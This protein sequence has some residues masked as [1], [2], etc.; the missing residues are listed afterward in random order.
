MTVLNQKVWHVYLNTPDPADYLNYD[1]GDA[2]FDITGLQYWQKLNTLQTIDTVTTDTVSAWDDKSSNGRDIENGTKATQPD[3]TTTGPTFDNTDFLSGT[4]TGLL[5][6]V[7][8]FF[9]AA[10]IK[11]PSLTPESYLFRL[12]TSSSATNNRYGLMIQASTM[13]PL[14]R[15]RRVDSGSEVTHTATA[16]ITADT[17][18]VISNFIDWDANES[19]HYTNGTANGNKTSLWATNGTTDATNPATWIVGNA[20]ATGTKPLGGILAEQLLIH[21]PT[22]DQIAQVHTYLNAQ[23]TRA[24]S[25]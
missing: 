8:K 5:N 10:L 9:Y 11:V 1:P 19:T 6:N 7:T 16:A 13:K 25:L 21:E 24:A 22:T 17:F 18:V 20:T 23:R 2:P 12:S 3:D 15:L 4:T 14:A